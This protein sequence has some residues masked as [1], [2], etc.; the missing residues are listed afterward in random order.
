M[1]DGITIMDDKGNQLGESKK[2]AKTAIL[3]VV[4]SRV[5]MAMPGMSELFHFNPE[6]CGG[7]FV[8][9]FVYLFYILFVFLLR[10]VYL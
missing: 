2:V 10:Y 6:Y 4:V 7:F 3:Q 1:I 8:C 9:V 5:I